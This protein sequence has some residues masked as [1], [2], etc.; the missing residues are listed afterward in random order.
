MGALG[1]PWGAHGSPLGPKG[2]KGARSLLSGGV[3]PIDPWNIP[4]IPDDD[5]M[6]FVHHQREV[7]LW[8]DIAPSESDS[9]S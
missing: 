4:P 7:G 6:V 2:P 1:L 9:E 8:V 3:F 5:L